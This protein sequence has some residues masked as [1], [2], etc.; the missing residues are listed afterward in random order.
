MNEDGRIDLIVAVAGADSVAFLAGN[1]DGTFAKPAYLAV[2][3]TPKYAV[4]GDFNHDHH[5]DIVVADQDDDTIS[6]LLGNGDGTFKPRVSYPACH[7]AH[8]VAVAD[9]NRDGNDD[10]VVACHDQPYFASLF[11]GNGDGTFKPGVEL[12]AGAEP[13]A[14]VVG[15]FNGDGIPD[16]AFADRAGDGVSVLL[17]KGDGSFNAAVTYPTA[18]SPHGIRAADLTGGG[19]LDIVTVNDRSNKI[20]I[21]YGKGDGTFEPHTDL[22]ANSLPKSVALADLNGDGRPD[23]IVTNTT[24]PTCCTIEGSTL[25]VYLNLGERKFAPRQDFDVGGNPFSLLIRDLNGDGKPD[26]TTANYN[27]QTAARHLYVQATHALGLSGKPARV[28]GAVLFGLI[29]IAIALIAR[30]RYQTP[31]FIA[32]VILALVL[33]GG[34][35]KLSKPSLDG[36]SHVSILFA[37]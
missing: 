16:L 6:V 4:T 18:P 21:L 1:G 3:K 2:G 10:V 34:F 33:A 5:R 30:S 8:E 32:G 29:G 35:Y 28:A 9:F 25:S 37:R 13:T 36:P 19:H 20:S 27:D 11:L 12:A 14:V 24:Y 31:G 22:T 15:D 23:I 7:G 26:V 17:G